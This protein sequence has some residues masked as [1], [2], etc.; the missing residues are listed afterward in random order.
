MKNMK[1]IQIFENFRV[2]KTILNLFVCYRTDPNWAEWVETLRSIK[3]PTSIP[4]SGV[5][6]LGLGIQVLLDT[7]LEESREFCQK[8][9]PLFPHPIIVLS[10][11]KVNLKDQPI[12]LY[13]DDDLT[14]PG[15]YF[16]QLVSSRKRG[17]FIYGESNSNIEEIC[18]EYRIKNYSINE[19]GSIDVEGDVYLSN[20]GYALDSEDAIKL[21]QLPLKFGRVSGDF[22]CSYNQLKSLEGSPREVG[23]KFNCNN[24][25]L[26]TLE[27]GPKVVGDF[28]CSNNKLTSLEGSPKEVYRFYCSNNQLTSLEG[29]PREVGGDFFCKNNKIWSFIGPEGIGGYFDCGNNPIELIYDW[30]DTTELIERATLLYPEL[31]KHHNDNWYIEVDILEQLADD[32]KVELPADYQEQLKGIGY[33]II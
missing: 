4:T 22:N 10:E 23:G 31:F 25:Q 1:Y 26:T 6:H 33:Q 28:F 24:N 9:M 32:L 29:A 13:Q 5:H 15:R 17:L 3:F 2:K 20:G 27:G 18:R 16:D 19:D 11:V 7:D 8:I 21:N 30:F 14:E 12:G